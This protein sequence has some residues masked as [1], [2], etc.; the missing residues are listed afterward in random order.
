VI[1]FDD[2]K[3]AQ[4]TIKDYI[5]RTPLVY[6]NSISRIT[7]LEVYIKLE[8]LQK[9]GS[10]KIRGAANKISH[11]SEDERKR[12]V[13]TAS[14]GNHAQGVALAASRKMKE[15]GEWLLHPQGIMHRVSPLLQAGWE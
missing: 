2:I 13:V 9:T 11:L 4:E 1:S 6:S 14:A 8:N 3:K 7:G 10:F 12:G 5:H 15:R